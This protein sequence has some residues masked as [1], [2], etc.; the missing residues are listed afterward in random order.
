METLSKNP[1][2]KV[3]GNEGYIHNA[4]SSGG[5]VLGG[6]PAYTIVTIDKSNRAAVTKFQY[7]LSK[8]VIFLPSPVQSVNNSQ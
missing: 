5:R 3:S 7:L 6:R 1:E 2:A 4:M 8:F